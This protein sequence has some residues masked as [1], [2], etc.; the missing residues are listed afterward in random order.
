MIN[1][2][3]LIKFAEKW[4]KL[5]ALERKRISIPGSGGNE[6]TNNNERSQVADQRR[7]EFPISYLSNNIYRELLAI[8][9]DAKNAD[10]DMEKALLMSVAGGSAKTFTITR[11]END[12]KDFVIF[13]SSGCLNPSNSM[14]F[15]LLNR[16]G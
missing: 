14:S 3:K 12:L 6:N 11:Q 13:K 9:L 5:A 15:L 10:K 8:H 7:F 2:L 16:N 4:Q 1:P